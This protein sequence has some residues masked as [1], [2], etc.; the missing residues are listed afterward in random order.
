M[1][2]GLGLGLVLTNHRRW[3]A[4]CRTVVLNCFA[5]AS[6]KSIDTSLM[7]TDGWTGF[8]IR[9]RAHR[10]VGTTVLHC[11]ANGSFG[12]PSIL[13]P[14]L[15]WFTIILLICL[16]PCFDSRS[17]NQGCFPSD[18]ER[19]KNLNATYLLIA[20]SEKKNRPYRKTFSACKSG[21]T[22]R[23]RDDD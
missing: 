10:T 11:R 17:S 5:H 13:S 15:T 21:R 14:I 8:K 20:C 3:F 19:I 9:R 16:T 23:C 22:L 6:F 18:F 7:K 12:V 2:L 1:G 4:D